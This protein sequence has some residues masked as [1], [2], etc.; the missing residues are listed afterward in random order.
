MALNPLLDTFGSGG[1]AACI[2]TLVKAEV[3]GSINR[4]FP[5][6]QMVRII[7]PA[8]LIKGGGGFKPITL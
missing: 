3:T 8:C 5:Q 2:F 4:S 7:I 6:I 1:R